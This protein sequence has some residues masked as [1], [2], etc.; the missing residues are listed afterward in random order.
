MRLKVCKQNE[1][2]ISLDIVMSSSL[3]QPQFFV[4]VLLSD[5]S[6]AGVNSKKVVQG[7]SESK[8]SL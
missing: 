4:A 7:C 3:S 2:L 6:Q 1:P 5:G 8:H